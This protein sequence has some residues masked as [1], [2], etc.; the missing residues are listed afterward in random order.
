[1]SMELKTILEKQSEFGISDEEMFDW[2]QKIDPE[3]AKRF[4]KHLVAFQKVL[5]S[6]A[7]IEAMFDSEHRPHW[8]A[9]TS[10]QV[11]ARADVQRSI[12]LQ[13]HRQGNLKPEAEKEWL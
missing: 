2:L 7:K 5:D 11:R 9:E 12:V 6:I 1:M 4:S 8:G 13:L 10:G 3:A